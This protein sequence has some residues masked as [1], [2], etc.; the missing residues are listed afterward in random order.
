MSRK[1]ISLTFN[2]LIIIL[3]IISFIITY[4]VNHKISF[5]Y[6]TEDSNMLALITS[7]ILVIYLVLNKKTPDWLRLLKYSSTICLAVTFFVVIFVLAPMYDFNYNFLL[8]EN[9]LLYQH[10]LC[11][12]LCIIT[13]IFFDELGEYRLKDIFI[14][15]SLTII[16]TIILVILNC[17]DL[18]VGP[19]PFLIIKRQSLFMFITWIFM[20]VFSY[21]I[22][23]LLGKFHRAE[24]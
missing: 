8:F 23:F 7:S 5:E 3:E 22:A 21:L 24:D 4:Y 12:I 17:L 16:Y 6:Y 9:A 11:P 2:L 14:G 10:L 19:Y 13:F 1:K 20:S 15:L 18:V